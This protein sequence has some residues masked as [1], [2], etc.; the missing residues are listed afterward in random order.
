[1]KKKNIL[2][3]LVIIIACVGYAVFLSVDHK[4][5]DVGQAPVITVPQS[6]LKVSVK[7]SEQVLLKDVTALDAEDGNISAD[8]FIKK[9]GPIN[10]NFERVVTYAV[11]DSDD[12]F[13]EA[14][15][16]IKYTDYQYPVIGLKK[17]L[18]GMGNLNYSYF[19]ADSVVDGDISNKLYLI[20]GNYQN[21][22]TAYTVEVTDSYGGTSS[23]TLNYTFLD[24]EITLPIELTDF[25]IRVKKGTEIEPMDYVSNMFGGWAAYD[26][27]KITSNYDAYTAGTY[28]IIY[29]INT[30]DG[31]GMNKLVVIVE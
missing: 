6:D 3:V 28:E 19:T 22:S 14:T 25:L 26:S 18:V 8:V 27:L 12:Q 24:H 23:L 16:T 9:V 11:L 2:A 10:Q 13:G 17:S 15:R 29:E 21:G 7:D 20:T 30:E 1:M 5:K 4:E 31:Y